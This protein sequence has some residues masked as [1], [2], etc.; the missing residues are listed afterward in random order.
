MSIVLYHH[1]YS[2]AANM[3]WALEEVGVPYTLHTVDLQKG[4]Q[5]SPAHL[6]LN[7]MG[8]L[9]V[10]TDGEAVISETSAIC[11]YLGDRYAHGRLAPA[12]DDPARGAWL[13]WCVYPSA[14]IEPGCAAKAG[15]W[16]YRPGAV[17]W[18][19]YESIVE[20]LE[21]G[22]AGGEWLLGSRFTM[23]DVLVG[24][25]LRWMVR[26]KMI[27]PRPAFLAYLERL[28]QRPA[29]QASDARNAAVRAEL[30]L[31]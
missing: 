19:T 25:S 17:G 31:G 26:F 21:S 13:R 5:K 1:P 10:L 20:T 4:E 22:L 2:R 14:V 15:G 29:L 28:E 27:D 11:M 18:G 24:S 7:P 8:K 16:A 6:A 23:A 3:I 9:P 30:G 12:L